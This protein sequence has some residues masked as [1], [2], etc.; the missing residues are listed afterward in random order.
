[1]KKLAVY[2]VPTMLFAMLLVPLAF[3]FAQ[4]APNLGYIENFGTRAISFVNGILVPLLI[5]VLI[6]MFIWGVFQAFILGGDATKR[7]EGRSYMIWSIVAFVVIFSLWGIV[8]LVGS[9]FGL[10]AG[11]NTQPLPPPNVPLPNNQQT[12]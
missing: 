2:L 1:M 4:G 9:L 5:S 8:R 11:S 7:E 12:F 6:L 3:A 10:D